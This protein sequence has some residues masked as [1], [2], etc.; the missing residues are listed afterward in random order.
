ML[1]RDWMTKT[2]VSGN[3]DT[4]LEVAEQLMAEHRFRHL[5]IVE[6][7]RLVGLVSHRDLLLF[8]LPSL[9][10]ESAASNQLLKAT[11]R[12]DRVMQTNVSTIGP[13]DSLLD[14]A[15]RMRKN[16]LG[17]LPVVDD[18]GLLVGL[19]TETDFVKLAERILS[20]EPR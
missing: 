20:A 9:D 5:P 14:A 3:P 12:V 13:N 19:I 18:G 16:K 8:T 17:C 11:L 4:K 2:V 10:A 15:R 6:D 1:V 7:G